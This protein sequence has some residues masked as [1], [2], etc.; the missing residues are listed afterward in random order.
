MIVAVVGATAESRHRELLPRAQDAGTP[1]ALM[2]LDNERWVFQ[3]PSTLVARVKFTPAAFVNEIK[4]RWPGERFQCVVVD[5]VTG[6]LGARDRAGPRRIAAALG[7]LG[8]SS[9][10][11]HGPDCLVLVGVPSEDRDRFAPVLDLADE[12]VEA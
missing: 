10:R 1:R 7:S 6:F 11:A 2:L 5:N 4:P 12:T 3:S 8:Q 9:S